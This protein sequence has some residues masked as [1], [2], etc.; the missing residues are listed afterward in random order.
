MKRDIDLTRFILLDVE[1]D[2]EIVVPAGHTAEE[3]AD[4]VQLC[5]NSLRRV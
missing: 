5:S 1:S 4:H 3:I 2:G